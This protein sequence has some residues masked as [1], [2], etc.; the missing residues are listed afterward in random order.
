MDNKVQT[1]KI[2]GFTLETKLLIALVAKNLMKMLSSTNLYTFMMPYNSTID[3]FVFSR[4][5]IMSQFVI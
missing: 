5:L 1:C 3:I 2:V 4:K